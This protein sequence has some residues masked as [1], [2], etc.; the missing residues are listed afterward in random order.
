MI[1]RFETDGSGIV[2]A[3]DKQPELEPFLGLH[4]PASDIPKQARQLY[5]KNWGARRLGIK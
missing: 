5:Y 3:E 2:V 1:Y 4:Y